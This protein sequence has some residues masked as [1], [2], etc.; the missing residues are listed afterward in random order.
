MSLRVEALFVHPVKSGHAVSVECAALSW[1]GL[2]HDR[3]FM[4]VDERGAFLT[5]REHPILARLSAT[6]EGGM[7]SLRGDDGRVVD[8]PLSGDGAAVAASV[9]DDTVDAIDCGAAAAGLLTNFLGRTARLVRMRDGFVRHVDSAYGEP[10]DHVS[11][12][13]GFPL[14]ITSTAS[15]DAARA[16]IGEMVEARRFRPNIVIGGTQSFAED[17]Y[18]RL[19][20]GETE[21]ELVKPCSRCNIL[22]VDPDAGTRA[23][24]V[25]AG[26]SRIRTQNNRVLFGQNAIPRKLGVVRVGDPV[27]VLASTPNAS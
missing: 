16:A 7:L 15:V 1:T 26:L 12:A 8:V 19:A 25:L 9:W 6:V 18:S 27:T 21:I 22:D 24:N 20:I 13:D 14:L 5:Q 2:E 17:G 10:N 4:V 11:F 3:R 23:G